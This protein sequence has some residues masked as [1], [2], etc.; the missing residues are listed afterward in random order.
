MLKTRYTFHD[1]VLSKYSHF[2]VPPG[3]DTAR[4]LRDP[5]RATPDGHRAEQLRPGD[6]TGRESEQR[7]P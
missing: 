1:A 5:R 6:A 7:H 2:D 4:L 3:V